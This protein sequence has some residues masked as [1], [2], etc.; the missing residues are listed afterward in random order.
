MCFVR[1]HPLK[2]SDRLQP[3]QPVVNDKQDVSVQHHVISISVDIL[4][5]VHSFIHFNLTSRPNHLRGQ[6]E[7]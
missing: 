4:R 5:L 6:E 7:I 1:A 3:W 2:A